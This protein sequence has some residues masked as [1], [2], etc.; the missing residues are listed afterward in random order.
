MIDCFITNWNHQRNYLDSFQGEIDMM[1]YAEVAYGNIIW[2]IYHLS[3]PS[4]PMSYREK[5][6]ELARLEK[7]MD[8][9]KYRK[10]YAL[11][12]KHGV[13][14]LKYIL[15]KYRME[16]ILLFFG[17]LFLRIVRGE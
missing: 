15:V 12:L 4:C 5:R 7:E 8:F 9:T 2:T 11:E 13:E 16:R 6:R 14:K 17:P 1:A 3:N 10:I